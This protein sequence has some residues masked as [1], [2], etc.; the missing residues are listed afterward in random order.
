MDNFLNQDSCIMVYASSIILLQST[1]KYN[2]ICEILYKFKIIG[3][4]SL[5]NV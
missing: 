3:L 5:P 4:F 2:H 1:G